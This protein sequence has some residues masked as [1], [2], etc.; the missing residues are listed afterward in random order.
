MSWLDRDAPEVAMVTAVEQWVHDRGPYWRPPPG[1]RLEMHP[2]VGHML[3]RNWAPS[4]SDSVSGTG[5]D[6]FPPKIPVKYTADLDYGCWRLVI[7][8]EDVL[9]GGD[10]RA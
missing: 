3:R 10:L 7:V 5:P 4:Y 1:L 2:S 8:T 6:P 9:I